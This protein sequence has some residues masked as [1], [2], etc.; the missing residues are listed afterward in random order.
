MADLVRTADRR[1]AAKD[2]KLTPQD[3]SLLFR[4]AWGLPM[5]LDEIARLK[6]ARRKLAVIRDGGGQ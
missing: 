5:R 2:T 6:S 3:A 1:L 4:A